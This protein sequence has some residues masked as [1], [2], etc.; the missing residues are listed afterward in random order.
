MQS[1]DFRTEK[2]VIER[3]IRVRHSAVTT[4]QVCSREAGPR[5]SQEAK[6]GGPGQT[7]GDGRLGAY[8]AATQLWCGT[9]RGST[10]V[11]A[12]SSSKGKGRAGFGSRSVHNSSFQQKS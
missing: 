3:L 7:R 4:Q 1:I 9:G 5:P 6:Q 12:K 2:T 10:K 11:S 8:I